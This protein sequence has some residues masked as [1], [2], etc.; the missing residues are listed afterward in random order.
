M[1]TFTAH[2]LIREMRTTCAVGGIAF[3]LGLVACQTPLASQPEVAAAGLGYR[4]PTLPI[5][6]S[7]RGVQI[8]LPS[9]VLFDIG[10]AEFKAAEARPYLERVA[11]LLKTKTAKKVSI[12]G[13]TDNVGALAPNQALS[14]A[15]ANSLLK[16]LAERGVP[17][18]AFES[19]W[20]KLKK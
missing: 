18:N 3:C 1:L 19:A 2:R 8:F 16:A 12:E 14:L 9:T 17:A 20:D 15:R 10:K 7:E 5:E 6:Q 11:H 4:G 13:H